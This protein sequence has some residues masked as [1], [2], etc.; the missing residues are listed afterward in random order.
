[1]RRVAGL[2]AFDFDRRVLENEWPLF[3]GMAFDAGHIAAR[4]IAQR[5][6][7]ESAVLVV[8]I[9]AL[10]AAFGD[11]MVERLGEGRLLVG[12]AL[13]A[14]VRLRSLQQKLGPLR[15]VRRMAVGARNAMAEMFAAA[16]IEALFAAALL[17]FV[18]LQTGRRGFR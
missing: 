1:M 13:I 16:E 17:A 9:G 5:F 6:A 14:H 8:A 7:H 10:H 2:T 18:T 11:F 12:V 3:V 15:R 4:G